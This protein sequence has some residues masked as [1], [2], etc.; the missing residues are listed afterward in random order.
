MNGA[1]GEPFL[2]F[3]V[4]LILTQMNLETGKPRKI[5]SFFSC[6]LGFQISYQTNSR[7]GGVSDFGM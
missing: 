5:S 7:S 1:R 2:L 4:D 3:H 6:I